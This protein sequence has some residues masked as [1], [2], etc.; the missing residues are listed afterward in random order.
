[1]IR[2]QFS[3]ISNSLLL[4][5]TLQLWSSQVRILFVNRLFSLFL[6]NLLLNNNS[7]GRLWLIKL[8][9]TCY[10]F[11]TFTFIYTISVY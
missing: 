8:S 7:S 6:L 4:N 11:F 1:M 3:L 9:L 2:S 5:F 10:F